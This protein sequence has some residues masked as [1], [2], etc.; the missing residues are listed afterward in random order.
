MGYLSNNKNITE[1]HIKI[2]DIPCIILRLENEEGLIP[3]IIL[4][5]GWSSNK[6][7]QRFRGFILSSLGYQVI[8]PDSI[9]HGER[10]PIDHNDIVNLGKYFW[11][12]VLNN[13]KESDYIIGEIINK[14][15]ADPNNIGV[16]GHSMGGFTAAGVFTH[17]KRIKTGIPLNGSFNWVMSNEIF[18]RNLNRNTILKEEDQVR[19]LDPM[20]NLDKLID[21]PILMLNGGAD[22]IVSIRPQEVFYNKIKDLYKD[23]SKAKLIRYKGLGH[24]VTTNMLEDVA[25]W[26]KVQFQ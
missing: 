16:I 2:K 7:R 8:I 11:E 15:D 9:Y 5:H 24:F 23:A 22:E 14:Y 18:A 10:N 12:I 17:D 26:L 6:D 4:Y 21:R 3:T 13:I 20:N 25:K 19:R 1:K